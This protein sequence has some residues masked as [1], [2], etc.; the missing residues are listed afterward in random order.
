MPPDSSIADRESASSANELLKAQDGHLEDSMSAFWGRAILS[1]RR[2]VV[3]FWVSLI[4]IC[5][6]RAYVGLT[7]TF[8]YSH[9][10]FVMFDGAW[11][12]LHGQ[13]PHV[14]F[15]SVV[16]PAAYLPTLIGL[17]IAGNSATGFGYGQA[18]TSFVLGTWAYFLGGRLSDVPRA[19]YSLC[20]TAVALSPTQLG[21]SPFELTPAMTYNR[22]GYALL[23]LVIL[24]C[25]RAQSRAD[26]V[27]GL[28]TGAIISTL[29]FVK[30]P[31][32]LAG[33]VMVAL[34]SNPRMRTAQRLAGLAFGVAV[35][36]FAFMAYME[37]RVNSIFGDLAL[38]VAARQ[39]DYVGLYNFNMI[40]LEGGLLFVLG[41]GGVTYLESQNLAD[42]AKA[43]S[44]MVLVVI[45]CSL[46]LI[47][48]SHQQLE[49]PLS[50][51]VLV[52]IVDAMM[53]HDAGVMIAGI[54]AVRRM[55]VAGT[56]IFVGITL[57]SLV[58]SLTWGAMLRRILPRRFPDVPALRSFLPVRE[59]L[60]YAHDLEDGF[61]LLNS[62]RRAS[63]HVMSLDFSNP[64]SFGLGI[65]PAEG[66]ATSLLYASTFDET[67]RL[68]PERLFGSS[69]LVMVPRVFSDGSLT[70]SIPKIYGPYLAAHYQVA[71]ESESWRLYRRSN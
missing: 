22:Y 10:A 31:Y 39:I 56:T 25:Y 2:N 41:T 44:C 63:E 26:L 42:E 71:A 47:L 45:Y 32:C 1:S 58:L 21:L 13:R 9:D 6:L 59:D 4:T 57:F 64:F 3:I 68:S 36:G 43:L 29:A 11:R 18:L 38:T 46:F 19:A 70:F 34:L 53:T 49:L 69:E 16:G 37:F 28:S 5:W 51:F 62:N 55:S 7:P 65:P 14:D 50:L 30:L 27:G 12:M 15:S 48:C 33:I 54:S 60:G 40:F 20:V 52:L 24:E 61:R 66:G 23:G 17:K 8:I 67:H 35:V